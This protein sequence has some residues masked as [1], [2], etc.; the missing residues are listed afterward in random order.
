MGIILISLTAA[1]VTVALFVG[2]GFIVVSICSGNIQ[3]ITGTKPSEEEG[4]AWRAEAQR[5]KKSSGMRKPTQIELCK[6]SWK[7]R[8][9]EKGKEHLA[10]KMQKALGTEDAVR[11]GKERKGREAE[12][13]KHKNTNMVRHSG[14]QSKA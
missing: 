12:S 11:D 4:R 1:T 10:Q 2:L 13:E 3:G 9:G 8:S 5:P 14:S 7:D 6:G